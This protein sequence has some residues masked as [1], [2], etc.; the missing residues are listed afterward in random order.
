MTVKDETI[1]FIHQSS[2]EYLTINVVAQSS[3]FP[4]GSEEIHYAI[5]MHSLEAME[6]NLHQDIYELKLPG[7]LIG[8]A[9][10]P[11]PDP[12]KSLRYACSHWLRHLHDSI[13]D[14]KNSQHS[15]CL[16]DGKVL[17]FFKEHI[18]HWLEVMCLMR[19]PSHGVPYIRKLEDLLEVSQLLSSLQVYRRTERKKQRLPSSELFHLVY[20]I[21]RFTQ[22]NSW[23]IDNAPLQIYSS[24]I[25]FSPQS[26]LVRALFEEQLLSWITTKPFVEKHWSP[27]LLTIAAPIHRI[28]MAISN[29]MKIV[30]MN[31]NSYSLKV[32]DIASGKHIQVLKRTEGVSQVVFSGDSTKVLAVFDSRIVSWDVDSGIMRHEI[33]SHGD[34][35][36]IS[37]DGMF[38]ASRAVDYAIHIQN[39]ATGADI[40][41]IRDP[42]DYPESHDSR[43]VKLSNNAKFV[44]FGHG[45]VTIWDVAA[46]TEN[47][48]LRKGE[49]QE[50]VTAVCFSS[51]SKLVAWESGDIKIWDLEL[52]SEIQILRRHATDNAESFTA[53]EFS[54]DSRLIAGGGQDGILIWD[55]ATG[56]LQTRLDVKGVE[57]CTLVWSQDS[58][59]LASAA[60]GSVKVWDMTSFIEPEQFP[61]LDEVPS[62]AMDI[63][64]SRDS[65]LIAI[66]LPHSIKMWDMTTGEEVQVFE[67]K[68]RSNASAFSSDSKFVYA[69]HGKDGIKVWEIASGREA[70]HSPV[71]LRER[72]HE[73]ICI[74]SKDGRFFTEA[75]IDAVVW[76]TST[77][78][79]VLHLQVDG[80][81]IMTAAFSNNAQYIVFQNI[82]GSIT[83]WNITTG[84]KRREMK[85]HDC[86][87]SIRR[88]SWCNQP[89][90]AKRSFLA[91]SNDGRRIIYMN[92]S[93]YH[94]TCFY[95]EWKATFYLRGTM[96]AR[97]F[98]IKDSYVATTLG[99]IDLFGLFSNRKSHRNAQ[100]FATTEL[101]YEGYGR[102]LNGEWITWNGDNILWLPPAYRPSHR[103]KWATGILPLCI[104][105]ITNLNNIAIFR[106]SGPPPP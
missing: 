1:Y 21:R 57:L 55:V 52:E 7:I 65:R 94:I 105:T 40:A 68:E 106:F 92:P 88:C 101:T 53:I 82:K 67:K 29:N 12:L 76:D 35:L 78:N 14:F 87:R 66:T 91:V 44:A 89:R 10:I 39:I 25:L 22:H 60:S 38:M 2:K 104:F 34:D 9:S 54:S 8:D 41:L 19:N 48:I 70:S 27:C 62:K 45:D 33:W 98:D 43:K 56:H 36:S 3:L 4:N 96:L 37:H 97:T 13:T 50:H 30:T 24:A 80:C 71:I 49:R 79:I 102:S 42:Y 100:S 58:K 83:V 15:N 61:G 16:N 75:K 86:N 84:D 93:S 95:P 59:I 46:Q 20:D 23:I 77:G 26:S 85:N 32:W 63:T 69:D 99:Y 6:Q 51:N 18:L 72:Q 103:L 73:G 28:P 11:E 31:P 5:A 74:F 17:K 90:F 47:T 81:E 64:V